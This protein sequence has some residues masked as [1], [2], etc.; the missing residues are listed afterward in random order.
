VSGSSFIEILIAIFVLSIGLLF[1][2]GV[3]VD[4]TKNIYS[5][6]LYSVAATQAASII[7]RQYTTFSEQELEVWNQDNNE[8]LPQGVGNYNLVT[9][10][11]SICWFDRFRANTTCLS[12]K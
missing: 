3:E 9:N 7:D 8:L 10:N 11:I 2:A 12:N 1:I 6:Y 5:S 4:V